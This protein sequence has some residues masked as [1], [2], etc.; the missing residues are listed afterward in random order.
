MSQLQAN[1][2]AEINK[3]YQASGYVEL[4]TVDASAFGGT[5]YRFTNTPSEAGGGL[6]FNGIT[7]Q[8]IPIYASGFDTT[9]TGTMPTPVLTISNVAKTLQAAVATLGDLVG[10]KVT[11]I[12]TYEKFLDT[13]ATPNVAA[14]IGPESWIISQKIIHNS[15]SIQWSLSTALDKMGFRFGRQV[16]KDQSAKNLYAPGCAR[17][18]VR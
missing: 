17:T 18:R 12:R 7:Y 10:A 9:S 13:G 15:T 5:I 2:Q 11:R 1:I 3:L 6:T 16:L 8:P 4:Y 14:F